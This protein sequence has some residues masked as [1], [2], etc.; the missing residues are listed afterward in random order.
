MSCGL[1]ER[2]DRGSTTVGGLHL[3]EL[4]SMK[5][6][7]EVSMGFIMGHCKQD[8]ILPNM[9]HY[10]KGKHSDEQRIQSQKNTWARPHHNAPHRPGLIK[11]LHIGDRVTGE[12]TLVLTLQ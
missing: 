11:M 10:K 8:K 12:E 6:L 7:T 1:D 2:N 3:T 5:R 4:P 9:R